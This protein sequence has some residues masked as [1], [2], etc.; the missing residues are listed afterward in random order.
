MHNQYEYGRLT[1]ANT[2]LLMVDH[3]TG[4]S[5]GVT[6]L[7]QIEFRHNVF[8]LAKIAKLY[9]LPTIFTTSQA[10]GPN[11]PLLEGLSAILPQAPIIHRPGEINAFDHAEFAQAVAKTE[12]KKLLIAGV[13]TEVCVAFAVLSALQ[14]GYDVYPVIDASGT[15]N[16]L[17]RDIAVQRMV[18]AGAKPITWI[19]A[20]A[21]LQQDWRQTT[22]EGFAEIMAQH[23]F[24]GNVITSFVHQQK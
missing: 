6:D 23:S 19:A 3:Q 8:A 16:T 12:R 20:G 4:I 22:G 21:E 14:A 24:Y 9:Q 7:S 18:Q 11:G 13:S 15:W 5:N 10:D 17:V 2:A 1:P